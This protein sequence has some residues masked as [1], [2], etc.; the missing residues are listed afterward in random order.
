M[1]AVNKLITEK[2]Q[3]IQNFDIIKHK[4][5]DTSALQREQSELQSELNIVAEMI[6]D[7][8]NENA[9]VVQDQVE[10]E[11]HY[12]T[13]IERFEKAENKYKEVSTAIIEKQ[14]RKE[15]VE[16]FLKDL[17]KTDLMTT[18]DEDVWHS[19]VS[20]ITV[21]NKDGIRFTFKDGTEL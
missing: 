11:K 19:L 13:L 5:F 15:Q 17:Q 1:K 20:C 14:A 4:L 2:E 12:K 7:C 6:Q 8:I 9:R 21:Y 18:F 16:L 10:Y 3:I